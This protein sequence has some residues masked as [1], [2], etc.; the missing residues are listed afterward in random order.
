MDEC[1]AAKGTELSKLAVNPRQRTVLIIVMV[2]NLAMFV[3]EFAGGLIARSSVLM[4][5]SV[6]M[7]GDA[8]VYALSL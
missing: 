2:I 8:S 7:L 6:D 4:A 3:I 1:C 5:E